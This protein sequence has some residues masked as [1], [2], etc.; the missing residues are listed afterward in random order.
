MQTNIS[1]KETTS[2]KR[3][4]GRNIIKYIYI[5]IYRV[6]EVIAKLQLYLTKFEDFS[7]SNISLVPQN[8]Y[9]ALA[10]KKVKEIK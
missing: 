2:N 5:Y 3:K 9:F 7:P 10:V 1:T 4:K 6:H 8:F